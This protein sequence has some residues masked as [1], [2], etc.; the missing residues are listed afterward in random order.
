MNF[1]TYVRL[2]KTPVVE[3]W[4]Y[5]LVKFPSGVRLGES[6]L[7]LYEKDKPLFL[8]LLSTAMN[9][10]ITKAH[11][12]NP[13]DFQSYVRYTATLYYIFEEHKYDEEFERY[14]REIE[15]TDEFYRTAECPA[16]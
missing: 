16:V 13:R 3:P 14:R 8:S 4:E 2:Q 7:S 6:L 1:G 5:G 12:K 10:P 9:K 11:R 15:A